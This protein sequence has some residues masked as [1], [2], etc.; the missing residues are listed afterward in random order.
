MIIVVL[1]DGETWTSIE[2]CR[3]IN[4]PDHIAEAD[5]GIDDLLSEFRDLQTRMETDGDNPIEW[6]TN[7]GSCRSEIIKIDRNGNRIEY[8]TVHETVLR[9]VDPDEESEIDPDGDSMG[10]LRKD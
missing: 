3:I 8:I 5:M 7:L 2:G 4:V 1:N 6:A 9:L 10:Y